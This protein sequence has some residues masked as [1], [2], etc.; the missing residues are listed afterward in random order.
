MSLARE[1]RDVNLIRPVSYWDYNVVD[2]P[3]GF[4]LFLSI[5][6]L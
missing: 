3:W 6:N 2:I 5:S 4:S 1:Y